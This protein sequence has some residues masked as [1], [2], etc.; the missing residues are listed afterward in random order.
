MTCLK[1]LPKSPN[2]FL[3]SHSSGHLYLYNEELPCSPTAPNYQNFKT[4]DGFTIFTC[5]SKS[6]RNPLYK[7]VFN[8]E[9]C[10]INEFG[11][12]PCGSMLAIVSQDGFLR[13]FHY[14]AM[15]LVG[16][17]RSYFGGFL[18]VC[19]SPDSKY[20]VVGGEDDL[21][22]VWSVSERRVVARGQGHRS[23][24]SVVAFDP[25]TSYSHCDSP[26]LSD[27][28]NPINYDLCKSVQINVCNDIA[29]D[30]TVS[31]EKSVR[32]SC[33]SNLTAEKI[34]TSYRL[35]S[36]GQD[37]QF[38]L[39]DITEDILR[40]SY[41]KRH[42]RGSLELQHDFTSHTQLSES[43]TTKGPNEID[44]N[45][46]SKINSF[47]SKPT[48]TSTSTST[49]SSTVIE[50]IGNDTSTC[51]TPTISDNAKCLN[52]NSVNKIYSN[53]SKTKNVMENCMN[54][55][56]PTSNNIYNETRKSSDSGLNPFNTLTQRLSHFNFV[57]DKKSSSN[58]HKKAFIFSKSSVNHN[59]FSTSTNNSCTGYNN[60]NT[61][62]SEMESSSKNV[63][64]DP[65]KLIGSA[66]CPR[67]DE[68]PLLEPLV[69]KKIAHERLT[70]LIFR[71]D[72]FLTACQD[73]FIY[74]W[75]RPGFSVSYFIFYLP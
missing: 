15:E 30:D 16:I 25:Y 72:C 29:D 12:S 8:T 61:N 55:G 66:A 41:E 50:S 62:E 4:G 21:V 27:D 74:T 3:A 13:V 44:S 5:K 52:S 71:E 2:L 45:F 38:C 35:G 70:A 47:R 34:S 64:Y 65:M 46:N 60:R 28:E 22:T 18:C 31:N 9:N 19:W 56:E 59:T 23:W 36:V 20:I 7:W 53:N 75:A 51:Q 37:T 24:V 6:T 49:T 42:R 73:G 57:N 14:D 32:H 17:A 67:F 26:D 43:K 10:S 33:R 63:T 40:Q 54:T 68:C 11:F 69:C 48:T 1:W 58:S 39:W